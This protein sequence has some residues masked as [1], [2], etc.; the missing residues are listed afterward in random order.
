MDER[1]KLLQ[2]LGRHFPFAVHRGYRPKDLRFAF[3]GRGEI[4]AFAR[5]P[6]AEK[7]RMN[8]RGFEEMGMGR[9][10]PHYKTT[11]GVPA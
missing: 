11:A 10:G 1:R 5:A 4:N 7:V 2:G 9:Y 6:F 8:S 3:G